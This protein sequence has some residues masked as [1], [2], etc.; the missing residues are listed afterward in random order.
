MGDLVKIG[1]KTAIV[2]G[3]IIA[4]AVWV[5]SIS[6]PAVDFSS[7]TTYINGVYSLVCHWCPVFATL[8][9][10]AIV[11]IGLRLS[12]GAF[13]VGLFIFKTMMVIFE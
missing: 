9:P 3:V 8:Y 7:L 13:R 6:V 12:V 10:F 11:V 4:L 5:L 1:I 2:G